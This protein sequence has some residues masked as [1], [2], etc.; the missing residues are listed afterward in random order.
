MWLC[1][2]VVLDIHELQIDRHG[3]TGGVRDPGGLEGAIRRPETIHAY[4]DGLCSVAELA[5]AL[6]VGLAKG[7]YFLDG[8]KRSACVAA[9]LFLRINGC[10]LAVSDD[11]LATVFEDV[12]RSAMSE[13]A[14]ADWIRR[15]TVEGR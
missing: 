9:L 6:A 12:A 7:H 1:D 8:N 11:E 13:A 5:A 4:S 15:N 10:E 14:L 2:G 3:G